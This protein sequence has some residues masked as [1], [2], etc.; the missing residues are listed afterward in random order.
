M[1]NFLNHI[2]HIRTYKAYG[3]YHWKNYSSNIFF[4]FD[5]LLRTYNICIYE[6]SVNLNFG[7]YFYTL[8]IYLSK[9]FH[10]VSRYII[11]WIPNIIIRAIVMLMPAKMRLMKKVTIFQVWGIILRVCHSRVDIF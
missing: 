8:V 2:R 6:K 9:D 4:I 11:F 7:H 10:V 3:Y 5:R 1:I